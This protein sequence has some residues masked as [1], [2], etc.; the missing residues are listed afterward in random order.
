MIKY[1]AW[2]QQNNINNIQIIMDMP[3]GI[4]KPKS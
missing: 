3:E 2:Y 4:I 1:T